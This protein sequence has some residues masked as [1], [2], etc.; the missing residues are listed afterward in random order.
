[1]KVPTIH[2]IDAREHGFLEGMSKHYK[3][4]TSENYMQINLLAVATISVLSK[5][6]VSY[7]GLK[8][9][10][11]PHA[12]RKEIAFV[13]DSRLSPTSWY[14]DD[15]YQVLIPLLDKKSSHSILCGDYI[16]DEKHRD[17]LKSLFFSHI[18]AHKEINYRHHGLFYIVYLNN[19]SA[20]DFER[21]N[22]GLKEMD[23]Y[24]GYFDLTYSS[25]I[26]TL[27]STILVKA[28][29]K[30]KSTIINPTEA[31]EDVNMTGFPFE[32]YG[33]RIIGID[34]L[35][36]GIFL[37]YKIEREVFPG[38][39][40]DQFFSL[41]AL[42]ENIQ[43]L[44]ELSVVIED[45]KLEYL[46]KE[47]SGTLSLAGLTTLTAKEVAEIVHNKINH[48]YIFSLTFLPEHE[49]MKFNMLIELPRTDKQKP[50]K[51]TAALEYSPRNKTIRLITLF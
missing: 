39:E 49:T 31:D 24:V 9:A 28:I 42:T 13:F 10:L 7:A 48:N 30:Y 26:K 8:N 23:A 11:I 14:G 50:I 32:E 35:T 27:L 16:G 25:V 2:T 51:L 17:T 36:Y 12:D 44:F 21:L 4:T 37:S 22:S 43:D 5:K 29:I 33:Y 45:R 3:W 34:V 47:K 19:L 46:L 20:E 1:M 15:V 18:Q 40:A 38:Y 6:K 41:N